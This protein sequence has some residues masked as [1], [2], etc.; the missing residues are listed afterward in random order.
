MTR[1]STI[2]FWALVV[3]IQAT[4][5][6]FDFFGGNLDDHIR[7]FG[8]LLLLPGFALTFSWMSRQL[9]ANTTA[10]DYLGMLGVM[11]AINLVL[12][13]MVYLMIRIT[14]RLRKSED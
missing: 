1:R 12:A 14:R 7:L 2:I 11:V 4:G 8:E 5:V 3:G 6:A 10:A 9:N 13:A